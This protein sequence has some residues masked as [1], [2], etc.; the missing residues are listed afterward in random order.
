MPA[1]SWRDFTCWI[2]PV[3]WNGSLEL[4]I[5]GSEG[6]SQ[7]LSFQGGAEL[8]RKS[9]RRVI[10]VDLSYAKTSTD[11]VETQHYGQLAV[12]NERLFGD[13]PWT[14]FTN[15][16]LFYDEFK[17][18]DVRLVLNASVGYRFFQT[19]VG[20]LKGRFG[21]GV[22]H[23]VGGPDDSWTP[24]AV[25]GLDFEHQLT[26]RQKFKIKA[27]YFPDWSSFEDYRV[28]VDAGWELLLDEEANL[29]LKLA[30]IDRYDSTPNGLKPNDLNYSLLLL[31]K[32]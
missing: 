18:F 21:S 22:S 24:E 1:E 20:T 26:K 13:S 32:L 9:E 6:N 23:E 17:A 12:E 4:G 31:W 30:A 3:Q 11:S 28:V 5:N 27:D 2:R 16:D 25:L 19:D 29:S 14:L 10:G 8:E 15:T 7:T